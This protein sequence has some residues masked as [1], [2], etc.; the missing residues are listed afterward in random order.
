MTM[1]DPEIEVQS[2]CRESRPQKTYQGP[3]LSVLK[4][5]V[6]LSLVKAPVLTVSRTGGLSLLTKELPALRMT[7]NLCYNYIEASIL[8]DQRSDSRRADGTDAPKDVNIKE[9]GKRRVFTGD[10]ILP[11]GTISSIKLFPGNGITEP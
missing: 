6:T 7:P 1:E 9:Q 11:P 2:Y 10:S 3:G 8:R 4:R 5:I